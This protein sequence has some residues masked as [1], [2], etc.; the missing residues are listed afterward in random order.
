[1]DLSSSWFTWLG[2][3]RNARNNYCPC[4]QGDW[5]ILESQ[6]YL[7]FRFRMSACLSVSDTG[8]LLSVAYDHRW[9]CLTRCNY[10]MIRR[11]HR[12][13]LLLHIGSLLLAFGFVVPLAA[14]EAPI[15]EKPLPPAEAARRV[16]MPPGFQ[17]TMF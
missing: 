14:S 13:N 4:A 17:M 6:C 15:V 8:R 12:L 9:M 11:C 3:K 16:T 5:A 1:M 10:S 7:K 2:R